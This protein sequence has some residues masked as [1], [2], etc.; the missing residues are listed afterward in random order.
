MLQG[1]LVFISRSRGPLGVPRQ[2]LQFFCYRVRLRILVFIPGYAWT[3]FYYRV[4]M[5]SVRPT[6]IPVAGARLGHAHPVIKNQSR[7]HQKYPVIKTSWPSQRP[8]VFLLEGTLVFIRHSSDSGRTA[9]VLLLEGT[10]G[11]F[12][13]QGT[14]ATGFF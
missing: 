11:W 9:P 8:P 4:R 7:G 6:I 1:T 13:L 3:G 5:P 2:P 14:R 12:L 10:R